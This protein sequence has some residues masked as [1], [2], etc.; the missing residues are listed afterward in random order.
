[1]EVAVDHASFA[2]TDLDAAIAFLSEAFGFEVTFIERG[3]TQQ[4][5]SMLGSPGAR[6]DLAQLRQPGDATKIEVIAF[7]PGSESARPPRPIAPGMG[8]LALKVTGF[9]RALAKA[10]ELGARLVGGITPFSDGRAVYLAT[11]FGL[12]LELED[13]DDARA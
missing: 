6:C 9:D 1:M 4:I 10:Q 11:P 13:G 7:A 2:V 8:H 5:A 12:F 3:M